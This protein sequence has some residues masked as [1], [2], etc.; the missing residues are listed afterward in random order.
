MAPHRGGSGSKTEHN[1]CASHMH[2]LYNKTI[3]TILD[4]YDAAWKQKIAPISFNCMFSL[5]RVCHAVGHEHTT[6]QC[7]YIQCM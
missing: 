4:T 2:A 5:V 7:V 3:V 1:R 6:S